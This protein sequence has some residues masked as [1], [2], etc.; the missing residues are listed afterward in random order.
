MYSIVQKIQKGAIKI[1]MKLVSTAFNK[2]RK[3]ID[4]KTN[5]EQLAK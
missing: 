5:T 4:V 1:T 2:N 3:Q